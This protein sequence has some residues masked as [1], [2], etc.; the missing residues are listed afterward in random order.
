MDMTKLKAW[1]K[2]HE[3]N[4]AWLGRQLDLGPSQ[5]AAIVAGRRKSSM[6]QRLAIEMVTDG[7]VGRGDWG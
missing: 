2:D 6:A 1:L 7:A 3:R 5:S 4:A